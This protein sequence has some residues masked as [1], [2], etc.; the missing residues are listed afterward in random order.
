[1]SDQLKKDMTPD[2]AGIGVICP[3]RWTARAQ[4]LK[5]IL[6][7]YTVLQELWASLLDQRFDSDL[8]ARIID[9]KAQ[10]E[11]FD[12]YFGVCIGELVLN[13]ADD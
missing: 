7:N 5:I 8:R 1:M 13:H 11:S 10:M 3:T 12:Y 4:S 6:Q 2:C 9:V